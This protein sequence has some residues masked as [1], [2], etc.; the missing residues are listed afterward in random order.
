MNIYIYNS[1]SNTWNTTQL[2]IY[3]DASWTDASLG[4]HQYTE[5]GW[6][7]SPTTLTVNFETA[8]DMLFST[9]E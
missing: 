7:D 1:T 5:S 6:D 3:R 8:D 4:I 2:H 9:K